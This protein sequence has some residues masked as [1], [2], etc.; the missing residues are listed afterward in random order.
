LAVPTCT[1]GQVR[2]GTWCVLKLYARP[3][4]CTNAQSL[5]LSGPAGKANRR[6]VSAIR[7]PEVPVH[8]LNVVAAGGIHGVVRRRAKSGG[9]EPPAVSFPRESRFPDGCRGAAS[10]ADFP[11]QEYGRDAAAHL[12]RQHF[13][14]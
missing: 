13:K 9:S 10:E 11:P 3:I 1:L 14:E 6:V 5:S 2:Y 12:Q 7:S 4:A 8:A